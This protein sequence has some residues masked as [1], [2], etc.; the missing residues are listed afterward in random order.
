MAIILIDTD[1]GEAIQTVDIAEGD[2]VRLIHE[3]AP[4][5]SPYIPVPFD[6]FV[7]MNVDEFVPLMEDLSAGQ[8]KFIISLL[9]YLSYKDNCLKG[10]SGSPL[11]IQD[12][13][14]RIGLGERSVQIYVNALIDLDILCRA[15]NSR[16]YQLY[17]NPWI[18]C[19]GNTC[20]KVLANMFRNYHIRS[21]GGMTWGRLIKKM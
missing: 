16:E 1:T 21:K 11:D 14:Y 18:A 17:M 12:I 5:A 9:P 4:E 2:S 19:K 8:I 10:G 6:S 15:R 13:S 3:K 20:N 7:K